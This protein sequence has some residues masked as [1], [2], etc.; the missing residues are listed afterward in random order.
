MY[1]YVHK[2]MFVHRSYLVAMDLF[3]ARHVCM[4]CM[5]EPH[6]CFEFMNHMI[7]TYGGGFHRHS[8]VCI[9]A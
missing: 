2:C 6:V 1:V 9:Y 3:S 8:C 4:L 7:A 5:Y